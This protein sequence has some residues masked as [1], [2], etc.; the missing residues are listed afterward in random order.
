MNFQ[1]RPSYSF[2]D[3]FAGNNFHDIL[4]NSTKLISVLKELS[5]A[6]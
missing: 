3:Y 4:S 5:D 1:V 2:W 6:H